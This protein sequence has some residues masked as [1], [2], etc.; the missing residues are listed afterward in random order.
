MYQHA[1]KS[2]VWCFYLHSWY[3]LLDVDNLCYMWFVVTI[4]L[5]FLCRSFKKK[6]STV[7]VHVLVW[8]VHL[9]V[10][11]NPIKFLFTSDK[12]TIIS[13]KNQYY[14]IFLSQKLGKDKKTNHKHILSLSTNKS[15]HPWL[16][17]DNQ[18]I[19]HISISLRES[20]RTLLSD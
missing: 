2:I 15:R 10:K 19:T 6:S 20:Y 5:F 17:W 16:S 13:P 8:R 9:I 18:I 12:I 11:N 3:Y 4:A 7:I 1:I 14:I